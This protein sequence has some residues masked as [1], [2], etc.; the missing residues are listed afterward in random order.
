VRRLWAIGI[1][2]LALVGLQVA[3]PAMACG[4]GGL[5]VGPNSE[6]SVEGETAIVSY[7]DGVEQIDLSLELLAQTGDT[8]L[9]FPTPNPAT[10]TQGDNAEFDAVAEA[11]APRPAYVDDWWG[12]ASVR[13]GDGAEPEII[14]RVTLGP[15][16]ATTLK[17]SDAAG[18]RKW[19]STNDYQMTGAAKSELKYYIQ[20]GWSFVAIKL[21][22][23][24][25]L[26]G[27]LEP[28]RITFESSSFVYPMRL[29][30]AAKT[31]Q[32]VRLYILSDQR[33]DVEKS[34]RGGGKINAAR[35][36]VWAGTVSD[37]TL[38]S[39]GS[40]LTVLDLTYDDPK[41]QVTTD[42]RIIPSAT[43]D[44]VIP[45]IEVIR[46]I[47]LLGVPV[48][49]LIVGWGLVGLL[50]LFGALVARTRTR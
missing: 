40:F 44:E 26:N 5:A 50:I 49:S 47:A 11:I 2:T 12:F 10:V 21:I 42:I 29:S 8:G 17:A 1:V 35:N 37:P 34:V 7:A 23:D 15:I 4:C 28:V 33:A 18:L 43:N 22:S 19:L 36:T 3:S 31:P 41:L 39:R 24:D 9:V 30:A 38:T 16:E 14:S 20:Q 6:V 25:V 45:V 13:G 32:N 46:P 48:G 27:D